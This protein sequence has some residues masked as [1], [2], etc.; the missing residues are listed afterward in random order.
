MVRVKCE[1]PLVDGKCQLIQ[2]FI[3][4]RYANRLLEKLLQQVEWHQPTIKLF[5]KSVLSPRLSAWYGDA[6]AIYQYSG[7][8]NKPLGWIE[9]L[10]EV[11]IRLEDSVGMTFNSVLLNLYRNGD[12]AM[13][14]H[15]DD[16]PELG[17]NPAIASISL[18]H[19][20][21]FKLRHKNNRTLPTLK[22]DLD[23]GSLLLMTGSTQHFWKH[24]VSRTKK[25]AGQRVNLTF[26]Q[27]IN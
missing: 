12:D 4:V 21:S 2:N 14:W 17:S 18:G 16:E 1:I 5:G 13:G 8:E 11:K 9:P 19:T 20:R 23:H 7:M 10:T 27:V 26:R 15:A 6:G 25:V 24:S 3:S 22:L